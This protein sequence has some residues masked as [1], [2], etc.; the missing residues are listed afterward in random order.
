MLECRRSRILAKSRENCTAMEKDSFEE[1]DPLAASAT[2]E[3]RG[4]K[5]G[6]DRSP[7]AIAP[8]PF[9]PNY[10]VQA[11][12]AW[13][14]LALFVGYR[15]VL[16]S[17]FIVPILLGRLSLF[18]SVQ[19]PHRF[20][21]VA[22]IYLASALIGGPLLVLRQPHL[23]IQIHLQVLT[24]IALIALLMSATGGVSGG[25]GILI[26]CSVAAGGILAGGRCTMGFAAVASIAVLAQELSVGFGQFPSAMSSTSA[27][28]LGAAFFAIALSAN[29]L[30][31]RAEQSQ[32]LAARQGHDLATLRQLNAF[33]VD[34]LQSGILVLDD[35]QRIR[36]ANPAAR[37]LLGAQPSA[38]AIRDLDPSFQLRYGEWAQRK[39]ETSDTLATPNGQ[40]VHARFVPLLRSEPA[41]NMVMLEDEAVHKQRVQQGKL[42]SLGR[43]TGSIAHE[44][45]NPLSAINHAAQLLSESKDLN[46]EERQLLDMILRHA[47]RVNETIESILQISRG[48]STQRECLE[49]GPWVRRFLLDFAESRNLAA[50]PFELRGDDHALPALVDPGHLRQILDN[51]CSN[52]MKYG[53]SDQEPPE[54]RLELDARNS[55][56][57]ITVVDHGAGIDRQTAD[58]IFEPFFTTSHTGVGLGL[59]IARELAELNQARLEYR[60][61]PDGS[62]FRLALADGRRT[63]I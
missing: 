17:A 16:G 30:S 12:Q 59:Y 33:I 22:G 8:C 54:I 47:R 4:P 24:D 46:A 52:A 63:A 11:D 2:R 56:P 49:L 3:R 44:I 25:L 6:A 37:R 23:G 31:R 43:L 7:D 32:L 29:A 20:M 57:C 18:V 40:A 55:C 26:A 35:Q 36:I 9:S 39:S 10:R 50:A 58:Q 45:R 19:D 34:H 1:V 48:R 27:G 38:S 14:S 51:L 5:P 15:C 21:T 62:E 61:R 53:R 42:D 60:P 41:L 28:L 13:R